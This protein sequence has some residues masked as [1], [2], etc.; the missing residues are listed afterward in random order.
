MNWYDEF[1]YP[2]VERDAFG[3]R[4]LLVEFSREQDEEEAPEVDLEKALEDDDADEQ[5]V[6]AALAAPMAYLIVH[7]WGEEIWTR[8]REHASDLLF[9]RLK[10]KYHPTLFE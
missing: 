8:N 6:K 2:E 9:G 3:G 7:S 5:E 10:K 4:I 1:N